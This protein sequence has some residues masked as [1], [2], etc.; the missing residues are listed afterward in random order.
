M[1]ITQGVFESIGV[2][3]LHHLQPW[4]R[5]YSERKPPI[6]IQSFQIYVLGDT[7]FGTVDLINQVRGDSFNHHAIVGM[8]KSRT[9]QDGRKI[10]E[11][12]T[13]GQQVYLNDLDIPVYLS[14]VWL[15]RDG[16]SGARGWGD[17]KQPQTNVGSKASNQKSQGA[18]TR[19]E[20]ESLKAPPPYPPPRATGRSSAAT[21]RTFRPPRNALRSGDPT[22][23]PL[24]NAHLVAHQDIC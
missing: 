12:K 15:K 2:R 24:V 23:Q 10:S 3:I 18:V 4:H 11:I 19:I 21:L 6:L 17:F 9:L 22:R 13:R 7:A 8:P 14:W 5:N 1:E 20:F 16:K